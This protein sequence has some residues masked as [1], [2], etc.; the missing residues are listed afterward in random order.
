M[1][2]NMLPKVPLFAGLTQ[3]QL[4][5]IAE[6]CRER[7]YATDAELFRQGEIGVG[8]YAIVSGRVRLT[9]RRQDG[10]EYELAVLGSGDILGEMALLDELPRSATATAAEPTRTLVLA[11]WDFWAILREVPEIAYKLLVV[12]SRRVRAAEEYA[13]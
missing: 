3:E 8:L 2:D 4:L 6:S 12:L 11:V 5:L 10:E 9:Q 13:G 1:S 7:E